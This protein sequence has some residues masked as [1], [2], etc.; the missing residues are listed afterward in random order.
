MYP[1]LQKEIATYARRTP[2]SAES[3]KRNL[4]RMP[5]G[6]ASN[7][8]AYDPYPILVKEGQGSYFRDLDGNDYIDHNLCFGANIA[9]HCHPA[10]MKAM[11]KC[12]TAGTSFGMPHEVSRAA[13]GR[14][15]II[16]FEGA[17]HGAHDSALV[18]V[19]PHALDLEF[20]NVGAPD[21][22]PSGL[23]GPKAAINNVAVATFNDLDSVALRFTEFWRNR[24]GH[25]RAS[26]I[27]H[28]RAVVGSD[29]VAKRGFVVRELAAG[30]RR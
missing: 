9:G 21:S 7:Y 6:V 10:V 22:V 25:C 2:K 1:E 20:G 14:D 8:R 29:P 16:K 4:K 28:G 19:K 26:A 27:S 3:H 30:H 11:E 23:G 17:Y 13:T 12:S 18:S 15:T 24:G 5:L